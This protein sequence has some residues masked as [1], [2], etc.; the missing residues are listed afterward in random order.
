MSI[1]VRFWCTA[2]GG[3]PGVTLVGVTAHDVLLSPF[4]PPGKRLWN[5]YLRNNSIGFDISIGFDNSCWVWKPVVHRGAIIYPLRHWPDIEAK[6]W[7]LSRPCRCYVSA[8]TESVQ[9]T[10]PNPLKL[11]LSVEVWDDI[12]T[13]TFDPSWVII[14]LWQICHPYTS[15]CHLLVVV[16]HCASNSNYRLWRNL[17]TSEH[18]NKLKCIICPNSLYL[19]SVLFIVE[20]LYNTLFVYNVPFLP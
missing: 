4:L 18:T 7:F 11:S 16:A 6:V 10:N 9:A 15:A 8:T 20:C 12:L 13:Y 5:S 1:W 19:F 2:D 14:T 17:R 3:R